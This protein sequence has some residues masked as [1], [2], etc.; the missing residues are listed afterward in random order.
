M[1]KLSTKFTGC[2]GKASEFDDFKKLFYSLQGM[3][4]F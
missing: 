3:G 4:L 2:N 1:F